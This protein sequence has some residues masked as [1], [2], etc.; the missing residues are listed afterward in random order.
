MNQGAAAGRARASASSTPAVEFRDVFKIY[1]EQGVETV[2]LRGAWLA[3][4]PGEFVAILGPSGSGKSTL[5]GL[6]AGL[7]APS[8]GQVLIEGASLAHLD[9]AHRAALRHS[10]IGIVFQRDNLIP[11]LTARENLE[12]VMSPSPHRRQ[13]ANDLLRQV[14]LVDRMDHRPAQ[15]SGG[16]SQRVAIALALANSPALLLADEPTGELDSA[17]AESIIRLLVDCSRSQQVSVILVTHNPALAS[18]ADRAVRMTDGVL[19]PCDPTSLAEVAGP[20]VPPPTRSRGAPLLKGVDLARR[21]GSTHALRGVSLTV[22]A[23]EVLGV[24]GPSGCGKSTLLN[25]LGALDRPSAGEVWLDGQALSTLDAAELARLRR[26]TIGFVFQAHNLIGTLT[27]RENVALPLILDNQPSA[28]W[29]ARSIELLGAVGLGDVAEKLPDQLSGGQRQR[30]AIARALAHR[31]R[32]ILADEPT[33][34][35]D[36]EAGLATVEL[37][38]RIAREHGLAL[39]MVTHDPGVAAHCDLQLRLLDGRAAGLGEAA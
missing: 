9:E 3:V 32:V 30:V 17:S 12:A 11:F 26:G 8:A 18:L 6:A 19:L 29:G 7:D 1:A 38:T 31:P 33:G 25:L 23:G 27:A 16:E 36:S 28:A 13:R 22:A 4:Q 37:L 14:G 15:L 24:V 2:A 21:F 39:V 20:R 35:L 5:L 34:S 10:R